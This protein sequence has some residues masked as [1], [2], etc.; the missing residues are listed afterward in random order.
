MGA[1][2]QGDIGGLHIRGSL[3]GGGGGIPCKAGKEPMHTLDAPH[4]QA[5]RLTFLY[6]QAGEE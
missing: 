6:W 4:A 3:G 2:Y 5:P 1:S